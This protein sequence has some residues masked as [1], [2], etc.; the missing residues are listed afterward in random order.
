MFHNIHH[1]IR[2]FFW[3]FHFK[4]CES[5]QFVILQIIG[6]LTGLLFG[7]VVVLVL[8]MFYNEV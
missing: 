7:V 4:A 8:H 2:F 6:F 5:T 3:C 1:L